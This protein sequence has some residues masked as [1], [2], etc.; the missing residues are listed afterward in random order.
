[1]AGDILHFK[2][3]VVVV[4]TLCES[5]LCLGLTIQQAC[6]SIILGL[7]VTWGFFTLLSALGVLLF[8][9]A[10]EVHPSHS[11]RSVV[12]TFPNTPTRHGA[13]HTVLARL[14]WSVLLTCPHPHHGLQDDA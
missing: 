14:L 5:Q 7:K 1:M 9:R 3:L 11:V 6:R 13:F 2:R 4:E 8:K 10:L 12:L